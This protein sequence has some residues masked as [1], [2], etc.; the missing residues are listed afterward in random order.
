LYPKWT[1]KK[2]SGRNLPETIKPVIPPLLC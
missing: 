1:L 2:S